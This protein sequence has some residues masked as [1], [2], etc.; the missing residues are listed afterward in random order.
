MELARRAV[1]L[2]VATVGTHVPQMR[3]CARSGA[4]WGAEVEGGQE[5]PG[6]RVSG[7]QRRQAPAPL[8]ELED[9]GMVVRG[10][11]DVSFAR[12]GRDDDG[13]Y[14]SAG[15]PTVDGGRSD[16]VIPATEVVVGH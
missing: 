14:S 3:L 6:E 8:D 10:R 13:R 5:A 15:T 1:P 7:R 12:P 4:S 16:V 9:R 2:Q 11:V